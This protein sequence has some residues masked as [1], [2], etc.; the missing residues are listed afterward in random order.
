[1]FHSF[2]WC[3]NLTLYIRIT[4][5]ALKIVMTGSCSQGYFL[6]GFGMVW[7]NWAFPGGAIVKN[8]PANAGD[9][10]DVGST[11]G[12]KRCPGVGN[13]KSLQYSCLENPTDRRVWQAIVHGVSKSRTRLSAHTHTHENIE[14]MNIGL[15]PLASWHWACSVQS[16]SHV[17][18]FPTPW[19][20]A[21]HT[22]LSITNSRSLLKLRS[23]KP[24]MPSNHLILRACKTHV[25]S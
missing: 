13:G 11:L 6:T 22:S 20:A 3:T 8:L 25:N 4:W 5:W 12:L 10:W 7:D 2:I 17:R 1:M 16:L 9:T 14:N 21:H 19:T 23:I 18:L 24:A 15:F